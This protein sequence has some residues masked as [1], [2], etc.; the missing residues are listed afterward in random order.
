MSDEPPA[1]PDDDEDPF[2][3]VSNKTEDAE[4]K[5]TEEEIVDS[6]HDEEQ[7]NHP[8]QSS[9]TEETPVPWSLPV[10]VAPVLAMS[11]EDVAGLLSVALGAQ[12]ME[13]R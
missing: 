10:R 4:T 13:S 7:E 11:G 6:E 9:S 2:G 5:P 3:P 1:W 8:E 12:P